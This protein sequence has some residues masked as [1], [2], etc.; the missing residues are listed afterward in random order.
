MAPL[1]YVLPIHNVTI[2]S[3]LLDIHFFIEKLF[4]RTHLTFG[5]TLD[6]CCSFKHISLKQIQFYHCQMSTAHR[7]SIKVDGSVVT[8]SIKISLSAYM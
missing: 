3:F 2:N 6:R 1:R 5:G 7:L 8:L 4:D